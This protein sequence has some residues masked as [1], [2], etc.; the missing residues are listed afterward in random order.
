MLRLLL[1]IVAG[2]WLAA[3]LSAEVLIREGDVPLLEGY[4]VRS[5]RVLGRFV[6]L[7]DLPVKAGDPYDREKVMEA[8]HAV[9]DILAR[10]ER[11]E[12]EREFNTVGTISVRYVD[13]D[14]KQIPATMEVDV[15]IR[16]Y[17]LRLDWRNIGSNLLPVPRSLLPTFF[18][19]VPSALLALNPKLLTDYDR[20]YGYSLGASFSTDLLSPLSNE[21]RPQA[22]TLS[23]SGKVSLSEP[24]YNTGLRLA[25]ARRQPGHLL[26][27][28]TV[29]ADFAADM[30]PRG[31]NRYAT[32]AGS[33]G[34]QARLRP[35]LR[36]LEA[37]TLGSHFR[38][39]GER[40]FS[41]NPAQAIRTHQ[42]GYSL[43][44]LLDSRFGLGFARLG[45]WA[46][47]ASPSAL[48]GSYN[49]FAG[50]FALTR[51][52]PVALNQTIGLEV[53]AGGGQA[54]G[55]LPEYARFYGGR[56]AQEF[57]F[58]AS[59]SRRLMTLPAGPILRSFG[60]A[61]AG[62][63]SGVQR[64]GGS[65]YW[66]FNLNLSLPVRAWSRPLIPDETVAED[67]EGRPVTLKRILKNQVSRGKNLL[68]SVLKKQGMTPEQAAAEADRAWGEIQPVADFISDYAN[69][70]AIKPLLL[71]DVA[72][73]SGAAGFPDQTRVAFGG[74]LQITLVT[75]R[76][77]L[78]YMAN[79]RRVTGDPDGAFF[80]RLSFQNLF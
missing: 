46:D 59:D 35:R 48:S 10:E 54:W 4:R 6:P 41:D 13:A 15:F 61:E 44:A 40:L 27:N 78:G 69:L 9:R 31:V 2:L 47:G 57:L 53:S 5:V 3:P 12:L 72:G 14:V 37:V 39:S 7:L 25:Y 24:F 67:D 51:E 29:E 1:W 68:I 11:R 28:W 55:A 60:Q 52:F 42:S 64:A 79:L 21:V 23:G 45:I 38:F 18:S 49:R 26:D 62:L 56:P 16:A 30:I 65:A 63:T 36:G 77:E 17:T 43:A 34:V 76:L 80:L 20:A 75:A 33:F 32:N 50:L 73:L 71:F 22:L 66:H 19:N 70:Y 74:G 8:M 58:A